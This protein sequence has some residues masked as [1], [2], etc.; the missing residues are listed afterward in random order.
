VSKIALLDADCLHKFY[1]RG[2][3][4]WLA[5]FRAYKPRWSEEI[6]DETIQSIVRR[7]PSEHPKLEVQ[8]KVMTAR[9]PDAEIV[10][11]QHLVGTLGCADPEDEHVLAAAIVGKVDQ[12]VTFNLKDFPKNTYARFGIEL[13][14]PDDFLL[15]ICLRDSD[16]FLSAT[17]HWISSY[18]RPSLDV[19]SLARIM[20]QIGCARF[21]DFMLAENSAI[22]LMMAT[23]GSADKPNP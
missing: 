22:E 14:H 10:G 3:L 16:S 15:E 1:L 2:I 12:L 19:T 18:Q 17:A 11:Y 21:A 23:L 7:F 20:T 6:L 4:T 13:I 5:S 9:F 8:I